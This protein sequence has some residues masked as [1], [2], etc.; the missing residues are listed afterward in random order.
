MYVNYHKHSCYSNIRTPDSAE[1]IIDYINRAKELGSNIYSTVEHG[2]QG[3]IF[4]VISLCEENN[5]NYIYGAEMYYV[6]SYE[7]NSEGKKDKS[8]NHII[9]IAKNNEGFK[10]IN[11]ALSIANTDGYYYKP[12][13]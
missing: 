1:K 11:K 8:N 6:P 10:Q 5:M 2:F 9:V 4:D 3:N 7:E 13:F 12:I